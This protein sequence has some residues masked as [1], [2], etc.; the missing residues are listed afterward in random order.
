VSHQRSNHEEA[1]T[2]L[3]LHALDASSSGATAVHVQSLDTDVLVLLL[4]RYLELCQDTA[5]VTGVGQNLR[6][7]K[8]GPIHAALGDNKPAAL[9]AFHA[10]SGADV[11]GSFSGKGKVSCWK[12]FDTASQQTLAGLATLGTSDQPSETA[13]E[14]AERFVCSLYLPNTKISDVGDLHWWFFMKKQAQSEKLPT[15][16]DALQQAVR[17]AH[18]QAMIWNNDKVPN[19]T[20]PSPEGYVW[21]KRRFTMAAS[22][23][24]P[25]A[26]SRCGSPLGE[27]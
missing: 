24:H 13:V 15:T 27:L 5:F 23:E 14:E 18:Y 16:I 26:S 17:R 6:A 8:P 12:V 9:T 19:P 11:T 7:I 4:R 21:K 20:I 22:D 25:V 1:D 3:V 10:L 2:K